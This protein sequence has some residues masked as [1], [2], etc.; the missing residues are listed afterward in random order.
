M[1]YDLLKMLVSLCFNLLNTLLGGKLPPFASAAVIVEQDNRYLV[2]ELPRG[3]LA[4]PGG[5]MK[6][7]E[8]PVQTA[9]RE[10][11][12][13]TGLDL[14]IGQLI[15]VYPSISTSMFNMSAACFVYQAEVTGGELRKNME[16]K[17]R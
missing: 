14:R 6:W 15:N 12:E 1:L 8:T 3:R 5:F 2:I 16:G 10:G 13:E 17:P 7:R 4:F 11:K 9:Q